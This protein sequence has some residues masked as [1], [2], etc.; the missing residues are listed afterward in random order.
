MAVAHDNGRTTPV[1]APFYPAL[2]AWY[3]DV[4][5]QSGHFRADPMAVARFLPGPLKASQGG[6]C[7]A[8]GIK[9]PFSTAY[10]AFNEA[11]FSFKCSFRDQSGW[12]LSCVRVDRPRGIAAGREIYG[13]PKIFA[14]LDVMFERVLH[15][16]ELQRGLR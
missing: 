7:V 15:R 14:Q 6:E 2:P 13:T 12:Y 5:V 1:D 11:A 8:A 10:G 16:G 3:R 9:M 4:Q